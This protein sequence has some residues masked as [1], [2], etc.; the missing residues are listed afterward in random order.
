MTFC[1]H[2]RFVDKLENRPH[3]YAGYT[4]LRWQ[5]TEC[6]KY[7]VITDDDISVPPIIMT[8]CEFAHRINSKRYLHYS[9]Y[10]PMEDKV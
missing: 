6:G 1:Y 8:E 7:V 9:D 3:K 10:E 2:G 4:K 5:L